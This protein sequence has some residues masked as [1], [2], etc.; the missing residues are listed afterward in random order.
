MYIYFYIFIFIFN[1][2]I[3]K[4]IYIINIYKNKSRIISHNFA[5]QINVAFFKGYL[6]IFYC[7][8]LRRSFFVCEILEFSFT[9]D[10]FFKWI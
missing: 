3:Y 7:G 2:Y 4:Y 9:L 8:T 10:D 6:D 1:I 5:S